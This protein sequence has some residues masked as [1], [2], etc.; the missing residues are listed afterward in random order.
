MS[1]SSNGGV[2][3]LVF[4]FPAQGHMLPLLDLTHQ[5]SLR[6][7]A[8]TIIITP[9]NLP[10]L[11]PLLSSSPS[12]Q[13]LILPLPPHPS[14]PPGVEHVQH[15]G[16]H[17]NIPII[18]ALCK[19]RDPII[20]WCAS[21]P[22]P[23]SALLSDFFLGWTHALADHLRIPR[24]VF[25]SSGAFTVAV[26]DHIW[27]N[28]DSLEPESDLKLD[29][30]P[31]SPS[32]P[33]VQLPSLFRRCKDLEC[34]D[35]T[36]AD[37]IKTSM[38]ANAVSWASVYN[39][40][41]GLE[42]QFLSSKTAHQRVYSVGPLNLL[43][44]W[45]KLRLGDVKPGSDDGVV[46]WLDGC[47]DGSV[48][49]V[50]FGSQKLLKAAQAEA[51]AA[52][53]ERSGIRFI[54]VVKDLTA[55]QVADGYGSVPDGFEARVS[56]RGLVVKGWAPQTAILSHRAVG[57]F[58]GHCGWNSTLEAV[59]AGVMILA[60][61]MEADQFVNAKL[62]VEYMDTAVLICEGSDTVPHPAELSRKLSES[63][64][65]CATQRGR[66]KDLRKQALEAVQ[67]GGS[68]IADL[69]KLAQQLS[70]L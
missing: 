38:A 67:I 57:G 12:I 40:I 48:L 37:F 51:L 68:S 46:A 35:K 24:I 59:A 8:I 25:Y 61:P 64:I 32:F 41:W 60:W 53:L 19:L 54:W 6:G 50:C 16:N 65:G 13:T 36:A 5:L 18:A 21:H 9:K 31:R 56:D 28:Y 55:Q 23:P 49:Y 15:I 44:G 2:H 66:A 33:W 62:L 42:G 4:P 3:I 70:L 29:D 11:T 14:L 27:A 63:M 47:G 34:R 58:L 26:F 39:S 22:N 10:I 7:L 1:S 43:D 69:D 45:S 20:Q 17:G 52:G 30:L